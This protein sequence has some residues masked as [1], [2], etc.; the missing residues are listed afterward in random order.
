MHPIQRIML[1]TDFSDS[2]QNATD[3]AIDF[4]Q[5]LG[6]RLTLLHVYDAPSYVGAYGDVYYAVPSKVA[7]QLRDDAERALERLRERAEAA[8][9]SADILAIEGLARDVI[10][11]AAT[12]RHSDLLVIGTHGRTG[13]KH[14]LLGS[15]AERV[16][17]TAPCPVLTVHAPAASSS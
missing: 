11:A 4:A 13:L 17:R 12:S 5:K 7:D 14:L 6:A 8:G 16:V 2:A 10:V 1:A 15:V 3:A 9:V